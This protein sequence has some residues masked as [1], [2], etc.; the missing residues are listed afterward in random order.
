MN[1]LVLI[2]D[3]TQIYLPE[4]VIPMLPNAL[5]EA[6][7]LTP[8]KE[9]FALT[10]AARFGAVL[11]FFFFPS[12]HFSSGAFFFFF[13]FPTR[14]ARPDLRLSNCPIDLRKRT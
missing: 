12:H 11:H 10:L 9:N 3:R 6:A 2:L 8:G 5:V 13:F 1:A 7:S 14:C 4:R